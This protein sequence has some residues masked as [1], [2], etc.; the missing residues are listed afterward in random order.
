MSWKAVARTALEL[1]CRRGVSKSKLLPN[2]TV[3]PKLC[4]HSVAVSRLPMFVR[5]FVP[6][7]EWPL[8]GLE[9]QPRHASPA[10]PIESIWGVNASRMKLLSCHSMPFS[11]T[12]K[13]PV[14]FLFDQ[15]YAATEHIPSPK[16]RKKYRRLA[17]DLQ[18]RG[19]K[20]P[21]L[22]SVGETAEVVHIRRQLMTRGFRLLNDV[23]RR[24]GR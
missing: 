2:M 7:Y 17:H 1:S 5:D 14:Q 13:Y 9:E 12:R 6:T 4:T 8:H 3:H 20:L 23:H 24:Y 15:V 10:Q 11:K 18:R 19:A 22:N 21:A 16:E